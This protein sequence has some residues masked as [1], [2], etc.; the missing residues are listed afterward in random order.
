MA[1]AVLRRSRIS[2]DAGLGWVGGWRSERRQSISC[3][4]EKSLTQ[5]F[6]TYGC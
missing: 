4:A 1:T 6:Y 5:A 3:A 2:R